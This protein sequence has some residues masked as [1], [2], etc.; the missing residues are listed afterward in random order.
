MSRAT[1]LVIVQ[2]LAAATSLANIFVLMI[3]TMMR[4]TSSALSTAMTSAAGV[5]VVVTIA[6]LVAVFM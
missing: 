2:V 4:P 5:I 6:V 1:I 3:E